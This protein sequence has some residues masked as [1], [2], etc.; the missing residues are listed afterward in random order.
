M[1]IQQRGG[2]VRAIHA[3]EVLVD[4][5]GRRHKSHSIEELYRRW[6]DG[7]LGSLWQYASDHA[8]QS[9]SKHHY[10]QTKVSD[11]KVKSTDSKARKGLLG[12]ACKI[13]TSSGIAPNT[14]ETWNL[15]QQKHPKGPIPTHLI[16]FCLRVP[17]HCHLSLISCQPFIHFPGTLLV[18]PLG[19]TYT[20]SDRCC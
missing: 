9:N 12:K 1:R 20:A 10:E 13:L 3:A 15:L 4:R 16:S 19:S 2:V 14:S 7:H 17:L 8:R 11:K 6:S 5:G 18:A